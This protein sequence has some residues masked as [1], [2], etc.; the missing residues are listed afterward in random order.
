MDWQ[1]GS[2]SF[3]G[4]KASSGEVPADEG[5]LM[6]GMPSPNCSCR[7]GVS[8]W[9]TAF[10]LVA[11]TADGVGATAADCSPAVGEACSGGGC[12][13]V[14]WGDCGIDDDLHQM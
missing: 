9:G 1:P 14:T 11:G 13:G 4:A 2:Y 10:G 3:W 8:A 6:G 7:S 5:R 12:G